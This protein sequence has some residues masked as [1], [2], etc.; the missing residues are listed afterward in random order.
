M[1][2]DTRNNPWWSPD[3]GFFGNFYMQ[4]DNSAHGYLTSKRQN[5]AQRTREEVQGILHLC[6]P[7]MDEHIY[8]LPCGYGRHSL[9]LADLGY[10]ITG[11]DINPTHL[12]AAHQKTTSDRVTF[13]EHNMLNALPHGAHVCVNMFYSFGFFNTDEENEQV[14]QNIYD[15]LVVGGRFLMHT[16]VNLPMVLRGDY[17]FIESRPL[18]DELTLHI[19]ERYDPETKRIEGSWTIGVDTKSYSVRIYSATEFYEICRRIGFRSVDTYADWDGSPYSAMS[20]L[21]IVVAMK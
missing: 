2:P 16:D 3:A 5:L 19:N 20:E 6:R 17:K 1:N 9:A 14:L 4:G 8:D 21:M 18:P 12:A 11:F 7:Q 15:A 10:R 13:K